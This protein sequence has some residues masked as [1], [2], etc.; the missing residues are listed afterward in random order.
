MTVGDKIRYFR[1]M[2]DMSLEQLAERTGIHPETIKKYELGYRNPK[3]EQLKKI[4][5]GLKVSVIEFLDIEIKTEMDL[6]AV[7]KKVSPFFKWERMAEI[8]GEGTR[9]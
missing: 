3:V 2:Q 4:A 5:E 1:Q 9:K 8:L 7:L 6:I